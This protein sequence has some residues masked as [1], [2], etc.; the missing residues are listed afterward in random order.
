MEHINRVI[1]PFVSSN[2]GQQKDLTLPMGRNFL[3]PPSP[4]IEALSPNTNG[5]IE[6]DA[7]QNMRVLEEVRQRLVAVT[8]GSRKIQKRS[9]QQELVSWGIIYYGESFFLTPTFAQKISQLVGVTVESLD[10][11]ADYVTSEKTPE[12]TTKQEMLEWLIQEAQQNDTVTPFFKWLQV[13]HSDVSEINQLIVMLQ[14][15]EI[16]PHLIF[17]NDEPLR[18]ESVVS[19]KTVSHKQY[20]EM[21]S[22]VQIDSDPFKAERD[23]ALWIQGK[24][25]VFDARQVIRFYPNGQ[26]QSGLLR[27]YTSFE[28]QGKEVPVDALY[29]VEFHP[30]GH[31]KK[32]RLKKEVSFPIQ[33]K[34]VFFHTNWISFYPD[35]Q[36]ENGHLKNE[37][38]F[39]IQERD[40]VFQA[41]LISF[42]SNGEVEKGYLKDDISVK[43]Q[44][45]EVVFLATGVTQFYPNGQIEQ[46]WLKTETSFEVQG[47][48]VIFRPNWIHFYA[49]GQVKVGI[50]GNQDYELEDEEGKVRLYQRASRLAFTESGKVQTV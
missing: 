23:I 36:V 32:V 24:E 21:L 15:L 13:I 6:V 34:E 41:L 16:L 19:V 20:A 47:K 38:N 14:N 18:K 5:V 35:G 44:G 3:L 49:D 33:G 29:L 22:G 46:G 37:T 39:K 11:V 42:Y 10:C 43:I 31:V 26:V 50:L 4:I 25:V 17:F 9:M 45:K 40:I 12:I 2:G 30:N 7:V 28:V 1:L 27:N 48:E 8:Q